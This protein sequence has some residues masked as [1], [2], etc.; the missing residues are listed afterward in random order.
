MNQGR[1]E[2]IKHIVMWRL[3]GDDAA[4][5]A[6]NAALVKAEFESLRGRVPLSQGMVGRN[7]FTPRAWNA[8]TAPRSPSMPPGRSCAKSN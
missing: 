3:R 1:P 8:A 5:R 6:A 7:T 4:A 2:M